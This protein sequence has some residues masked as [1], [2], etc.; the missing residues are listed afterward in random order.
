MSF[1]SDLAL[2]YDPNEQKKQLVNANL[3]Q[4]SL[5]GN[6]YVAQPIF[7]TVDSVQ[8]ADDRIAQRREKLL[9]T[10]Y[11]PDQRS[12]AEAFGLSPAE[13][14]VFNNKSEK[15][16]VLRAAKKARAR[17]DERFFQSAQRA[18]I[19][20]NGKFSKTGS[21]LTYKRNTSSNDESPY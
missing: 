18:S 1:L 6:P 9:S 3:G 14:V 16:K 5:L 19:S 2:Q 13:Y 11:S 10:V 15:N 8:A 21:G 7:Q 17:A 4:T 20:D 12:R